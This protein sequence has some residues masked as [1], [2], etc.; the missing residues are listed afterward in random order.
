VPPE[1]QPIPWP[2]E[3]TAAAH[4]RFEPIAA[5][6]GLVYRRRSHW[7]NSVPAH[8]A[9]LWAD[10]HGDGE[11]FRRRVYRAYFGDLL[12]IGSNDVLIELATDLGLPGSD[13]RRA[14]DEGRYG[15]EVARQFAEARDAGITGVPA[16][17]AGR[18]VMVGAQ[19]A[20][21]YRRL[22]ETAQAEEPAE[23]AAE[24]PA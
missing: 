10:E 13:L 11:E 23:T 12:N 21:V 8:E 7:Y 5:A 1:G 19:P 16:Y 22:I 2:A 17:I 24:H 15:D 20:D 6:E 9:A 18:Y 4:A 3:R 14:L